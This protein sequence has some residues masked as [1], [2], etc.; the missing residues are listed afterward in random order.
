MSESVSVGTVIN[1]QDLQAAARRWW[2]LAVIGAITAILGVV[3][4]V[5]P[6]AGEFAL[7]VFIAAGFIISGLG[8]LV[9]AGRWPRMWVPVVWGLLSLAAGVVTIVWPGITL[10]VLAVVIGLMLI[11]RGVIAAMGALADK[12]HGWGV[13]L[14]IGVVEVAAGVAAIAWPDVTILIVAIILGIDL[15]IAGLAELAVAFQLRTLR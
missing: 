10:E 2:V 3:V 14:V 7:A 5:R 4:I 15:L 13:W 6:V 12:P 11:V 1:D 8:D 9:T